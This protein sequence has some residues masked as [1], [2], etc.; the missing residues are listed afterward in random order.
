MAL[1]CQKFDDSTFW[2]KDS[3]ITPSTNDNSDE[4]WYYYHKYDINN[5]ALL[6]D[7]DTP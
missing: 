6:I 2:V 7:I 5:T 4:Y 1:K 3:S